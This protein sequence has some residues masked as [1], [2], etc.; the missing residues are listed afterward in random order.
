MLTTLIPF[1]ISIIP[2]KILKAISE[3]IPKFDNKLAIVVKNSMLDK[4]EMITEN[5]TTK[6]PIDKIVEIDF[7]MASPKISPKLA[8]LI[9]SLLSEW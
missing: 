1:V 3:G 7:L 2:V 9:N 5:K 4:I 8:T 6:P